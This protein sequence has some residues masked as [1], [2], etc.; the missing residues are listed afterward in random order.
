MLLFQHVRHTALNMRVHVVHGILD[1]FGT[2]GILQLVPYLKQAGFE[3]RVPDY[4]L[5]TA[6]ETKFANPIITRTLYPYVDPGD[7]YIGHSNGCAIGY[8][9]V[10]MGTQFAGMILINAALKC[11]IKL[12]AATWADVYFNDD[13]DATVAA[14]AASE[15]G[16]VDPCWGEMGHSGYLGSNPNITNIDCANKVGMP[17]VSGHSDIFKLEKL[18]VWGPYIVNRLKMRL[19]R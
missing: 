18:P 4:G 7:I 12:P 13:D 14:E 8:D 10:Q 15:L 11:N 2:A 6:L 5:I 3:V 9:L 19:A 17:P 16:M 1:A